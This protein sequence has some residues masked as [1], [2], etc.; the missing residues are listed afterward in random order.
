MSGTTRFLDELNKEV[1]TLNLNHYHR[2]ITT[3]A[4]VDVEN[5]SYMDDNEE[6]EVIIGLSG[7]D[8]TSTYTQMDEHENRLTTN[9]TAN[10]KTAKKQE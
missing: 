3:I 2:D 5:D 8:G 9:T 4:K 6:E 7:E 1:D 10:R